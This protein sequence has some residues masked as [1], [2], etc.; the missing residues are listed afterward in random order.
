MGIGR[1]PSSSP[2]MIGYFGLDWAGCIAPRK[3]TED[4]AFK[5]A[6][7]AIFW[8]SRKHT[9]VAISSCEAED[10]SLCT[11]ARKA[12]WVFK[13]LCSCL[14]R[15]GRTPI[16]LLVD[17]QGYTTSAENMYTKA[18]T[19]HIDI[20]YQSVRETV[21]SKQVIMAYSSSCDQAADVLARPFLCVLYEEMRNLLGI[22]IQNSFSC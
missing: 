15:T 6:G 5:M 3:V 9:I 7:G 1:G 17:D 4:Y 21:S 20:R 16:C 13:V 2:L 14:E 12:I 18:R 10:N 11:A 22:V 19:K 8:R